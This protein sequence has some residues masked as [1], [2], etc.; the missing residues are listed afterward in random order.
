MS[1]VKSDIRKVEVACNN[2]GSTSSSV[3]VRGS[4]HEYDNT[5]DDTFTFVQCA[6]CALIYLNPRPAST[7]L[8]TIYPDNYY[9]YGLSGGAEQERVSTFSPQ[10]ISAILQLRRLRRL[11]PRIGRAD[12]SSFKLLD[13]GCGD[14][15]QLNIWKQAFDGPTETF[16]VEFNPKAAAAARAQGH[17]V[18][19]DTF[20]DAAIDDGPFDLIYSLQ[21]I[22][23]VPDPSAFLG[24]V[25]TELAPTGRV[26]IDT[27]NVDSLNRTIFG[28]HWGGY[29]IPRHWNLYSPKTF[30]TLAKKASFEVEQVQFIPINMYWVW[31]LHSLLYRRFPRLAE[32]LFS[33]SKTNT[34]GGVWPAAMLGG[35]SVLE[36]LSYL[37][38][39]KTSQMR[40]VLRPVGET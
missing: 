38:T 37:A 12:T 29:H 33:P 19:A 24:K 27:P 7:E 31:G 1:P 35:F 16:G 36:Y 13:I 26:V 22:E 9:A 10:K 14:G 17:H 23:H 11:A 3:V 8:G 5:T 30:E 6:S 21:V 20:E 34:K 4:D 25:R 28:R 15:A 32:T 18:Y 40:L 39:R 2:C